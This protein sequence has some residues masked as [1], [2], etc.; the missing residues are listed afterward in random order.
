MTITRVVEVGDAGNRS[1][2][3]AVYQTP[4]HFLCPSASHT[5]YHGGGDCVIQL[6]RHTAQ[7]PCGARLI[8]LRVPLP[9]SHGVPFPDDFAEQEQTDH[10]EKLQHT[11]HD[12]E[13]PHSPQ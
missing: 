10:R 7:A 8:A 9:M 2:C 4:F 6:K 1:V 5:F 3:E 13:L 12:Q 11:D